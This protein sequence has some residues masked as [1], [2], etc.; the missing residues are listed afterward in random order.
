MSKR[1]L[2][3]A[4]AAFCTLALI[5]AAPSQAEGGTRLLRQPTLSATHVAFTYGADLWI[6]EREGGLARRLTSTAAVESDPHFSPDGRWL[7]FSSNRSGVA[8]VYRLPVEGGSPE[9]LTWYPEPSIARGWTPDGQKVLYSS[10]RQTAPTNYGRL[11]TVPATGGP[12]EMLAAGWGHD[13]SFAPD[14]H[15]LIVDRVA[16]WDVEWRSY[17]GGQ[18][19]PLN[20]LDLRDWSEVRLPNDERSTDIEPMWLGDTVYFLSDR[21]WA[22]NVWAYNPANG[23]LRQ[24]THFKDADVKTLGGYGQTL[25]FEQNGY[26]HLLEPGG[27]P[28]QLAIDVRGDFPWAEARW[29]QVGRRV[30]SASLSPAGK[31][32]LFETRGE[33]FTVPVE[34]GDARNLTRS[35]G[36]ADRSPMWSPDGTEI[37]YF[38]D[39][40]QGY[41]LLIAAQDGLSAPRKLALGESKMAWESTWSPDGQLIAFAD[42]KVRIRILEVKSGKVSSVDVA[43][44]NI[45]RGQMGLVWS[46]DSQWLAYA[47]TQPNSLRQIMIWSRADN[48]VRPL[49]DPMA[50]A[51]A[52]AWDRGGRLLFFVASTDVALGTGWANTSAMKATPK[53]GVYA[54][55][56]RNDEAT[57]F[58]LE[59]DEEEAAAADAAV[60]EET[61]APDAKDKKKGKPKKDADKKDEDKKDG[62]KDGEGKPEKIE[63]RIDF[64]GIAR[65]VIALPMPVDTY[66]LTLAGPAG[67]LFVGQGSFDDPNVVLHKFVLKDREAKVFL[68]GVRS[69]AISADGAKLLT[70]SGEQ[71]SVVG[72][73]APPEPGKGQLNVD[74]RMWLDPLAEW[75]QIFEEAW[76]YQRDFFYDPAMHGND[77]QAVHARYAPLLPFIRHRSDL[78]YVLD[79]INGE[80]SVGHSFVF[81]GDFP[82]VDK[83]SVG[84]LG[85]D[86]RLDQGHWKIARIFTLESWNPTL[87]AP[88][89]EA[90]LKVAEGNYLVGIDGV[91]LKGGDD[92]YRLLDGTAGRQTVLEINDKPSR[93]GAW[94]IKVEPIE[95]EGDLLQRAWVEDNRRMV[96]KLS[97]GRLAYIWVPDTG[98]SGVVSF[99]RYYFAQQDKE[100]AVIDERYNGGG[101]LDDYMVDLMTRKLRAAITNEVPGGRPFR[102]PAG[103]LGPKVLLINELA[104]SGGDFF[105]WIFRQQKV[106][107]LIGARTWGGLVKSSIHYPMVDGGGIT[108]PDN[109]VFDPIGKRW[110]A[111]NEGV[112][113]DIEVLQDAK[114]LAD[115]R[116]PQLERGVQEA[117]RLLAAQPTPVVEAPAYSKPSRRPGG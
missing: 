7:A 42:E 91:E 33:V 87:S 22:M 45:E 79:M 14:G 49:S 77:W 104:G 26:L 32:A 16:R 56:L 109:A 105:P 68:S 41:E 5:V 115:G 12:S 65:R 73:E 99:D 117:L 8:S 21:D 57:P 94:K 88:L 86:L 90:G 74:L 48:K 19:T 62:D 43:G 107:P 59:S 67:I 85:A 76:H 89:A 114:S 2:P 93:V 29:T 40:G 34:K 55:I 116:D 72:T 60:G 1:Y 96:D 47:K 51:A 83:P 111:E 82:E 31:R 97:G 37:A 23:A 9:R 58:G 69:P 54:A 100:G 27:Q 110:V 71:W 61:A 24:I 15:R 44:V 80:L 101:L 70:R 10:S 36:S 50:D 66:V 98:S 38:S 4:W 106:G 20:V 25:V 75:R 92:P 30:P 52:P 112:P 53:S 39:A 64:D 81:G 78:N 18:N 63:V 95:S 103:I 13:A 102:L 3:M 17:R 6:A 28:R 108:A 46:P 35:P 11:W 84:V 113:P